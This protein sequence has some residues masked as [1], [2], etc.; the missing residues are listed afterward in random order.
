MT[1]YEIDNRLLEL[2]DP[3]TGEL[4]DFDAFQAL[5]ME[6]LDKIE[7]MA[8]W[9]KDLRAQAEAIK[10][11]IVSLTERRKSAERTI[12][13]LTGYIDQS[14]NGDK[15][16]T[17][18]CNISYRSSHSL[19][20]SN[21]HDAAVWLEDNGHLDLV[22]YDAPKIDKRAVANLVASGEPV[23]GVELVHKQSMQVK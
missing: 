6:R 9:V 15:F 2:V 20:V 11:E 8:L 14:L 16:S 10:K 1:L 22:T 12:E 19:E 4:L 17:A 18:R 5:Q 21:A 7:G 13:R 23:P 3:E